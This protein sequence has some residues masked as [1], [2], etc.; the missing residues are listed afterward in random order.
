MT[1]AQ[2]PTGSDLL[3]RRPIRRDL[4]ARFTPEIGLVYIYNS[5]NNTK[6]F[7]RDGVR[8]RVAGTPDQVSADAPLTCRSPLGLS[9]ALGCVALGLRWCA[10]LTLISSQP[11]GLAVAPGAACC[12]PAALARRGRRSAR[13]KSSK[14]AET[15]RIKLGISVF[16]AC[17]PVSC[18][19]AVVAAAA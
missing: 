15:S 5:T 3:T 19:V 1:A 12:V 14:K 16:R 18:L 13:T 6:P 11:Q 9:A 8:L 4:D 17:T 10:C 2:C 7:G